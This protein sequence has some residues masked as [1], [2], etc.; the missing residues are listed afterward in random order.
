MRSLAW[1]GIEDNHRTIGSTPVDL[2]AGDGRSGRALSR[3]ELDR[4]VEA[5]LLQQHRRTAIQKGSGRKKAMG[6]SGKLY[7]RFG[8]TRLPPPFRFV[9]IARRFTRR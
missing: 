3:A 7:E 2:P 6:A 1:K 4:D 9:L 8:G 5:L